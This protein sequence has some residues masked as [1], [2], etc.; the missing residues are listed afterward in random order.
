MIILSHHWYCAQS[1]MIY[2]DSNWTY[3]VLLWQ[4]N[5]IKHWQ[6]RLG[7]DSFTARKKIVLLTFWENFG[8][9]SLPKKQVFQIIEGLQKVLRKNSFT[10]VLS[11]QS[12][13]NKLLRKKRTKKPQNKHK[14]KQKKRLLYWAPNRIQWGNRWR[15]LSRGNL[16]GWWA[17]LMTPVVY[18]TSACQQ[19][20]ALTEDWKAPGR[21]LCW[22]LQSKKRERGR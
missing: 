19:R 20:P 2:L 22:L 14:T 13:K 1:S 12:D 6:Y 8:L 11:K 21:F 18:W 7:Y 15:G 16:Q 4:L 9:K 5:V 17:T 3:S 10:L